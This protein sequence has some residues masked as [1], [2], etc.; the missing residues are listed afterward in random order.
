MDLG[1][2]YILE[3]G[4]K[5]EC[6]IE[7]ITK[8][9]LMYHNFVRYVGNTP[10][11]PAMVAASALH[12]SSRAVE[13]ELEIDALVFLFYHMVNGTADNL[14]PGTMKFSVLKKSLITIICIMQRMLVFNLRYNIAHQYLAT[15]LSVLQQKA[16]H[17]DGFLEKMGD[18]SLKFIN[19]FYIN[20][21]CLNYKPADICIA[22]I[23]AALQV[24]GYQSHLS[25]L[26]PWFHGFSDV[27]ENKVT[28]MVHNIFL[29]YKD[30]D[31]MVSSTSEEDDDSVE[32]NNNTVEG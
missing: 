10:Y 15:F 22:C 32:K 19:D 18:T 9:L 30:K 3:A 20:K 28:E 26:Q 24:H 23:E 5:A 21:M 25:A 6:D 27:S 8:A 11:D 31:K 29:L 4:A 16:S 2:D 1:I 13:K 12:L 7:L 17:I 14:H